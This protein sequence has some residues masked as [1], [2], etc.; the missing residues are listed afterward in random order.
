MQVKLISMVAQGL[1]RKRIME[2]NLTHIR[3]AALHGV[4]IN[5]VEFRWDTDKGQ[6]DK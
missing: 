5:L 4:S 3:S 2:G 1:E 6:V